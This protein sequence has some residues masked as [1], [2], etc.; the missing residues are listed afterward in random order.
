MLT[1]EI[2]IESAGMEALVDCMVT[3]YKEKYERLENL[4]E[5][6]KVNY[7]SLRQD[8]LNLRRQYEELERYAEEQESRANALHDVIDGYINR[9]GPG[10][11]RDL[12]E[13][14]NEV[15][16]NLDIDIDLLSNDG[17]EFSIG[18]DFSVES[19]L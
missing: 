18:S 16:N 14:F 1:I 3:F 11:R 19:L 10:I 8:N 17:S 15:A 9:S 5:A 13:A 2:I 12:M 4:F 6:L 7:K